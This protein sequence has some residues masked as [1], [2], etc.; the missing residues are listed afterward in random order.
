MKGIAESVKKQFDKQKMYGFGTSNRWQELPNDFAERPNEK[1]VT[2]KRKVPTSQVLGGHAWY[3]VHYDDRSK[4][5]NKLY[6][7]A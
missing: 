7:V 1:V 4:K 2:I 6:M 5:I 3:E